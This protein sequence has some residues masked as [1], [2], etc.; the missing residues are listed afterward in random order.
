M[1]A[2]LDGKEGRKQDLSYVQVGVHLA[3]AT[4]T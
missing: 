2:S 3:L 4:D 1:H